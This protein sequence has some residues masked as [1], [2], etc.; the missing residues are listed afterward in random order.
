MKLG[1]DAKNES[2]VT[3]TLEEL[4]LSQLEDIKEGED[5]TVQLQR[6]SPIR[7]PN[8]NC[9]E[10]AYKQEMPIGQC[11]TSSIFKMKEPNLF[12][13]TK[14]IAEWKA[15]MREDIDVSKKNK[16][17]MKKK[18]KKKQ[19]INEDRSNSVLRGRIVESNMWLLLHHSA[20]NPS[21]SK[22]NRFISNA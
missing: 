11:D 21:N 10:A 1:D 18:K 5:N 9:I 7:K 16:K 20:R 13:E 17:K 3:L 6:S 2:Q 8:P 14:G 19:R 15:A 12:D 22:G 4:Q